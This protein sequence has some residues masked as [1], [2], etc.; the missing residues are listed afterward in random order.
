MKTRFRT[1]ILACVIASPLAHAGIPVA[2]D[3][4]LCGTCSGRRSKTL[5]G[6]GQTLPVT[7]TGI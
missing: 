6:N 2:V 7:N 1:L 3:A 5:D 4:D